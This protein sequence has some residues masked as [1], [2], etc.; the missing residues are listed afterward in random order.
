MSR[1]S[2]NLEFGQPVVKN[3][4]YEAFHFT[5]YPALALNTFLRKRVFYL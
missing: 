2:W 4:D 5:T 1:L 3:K